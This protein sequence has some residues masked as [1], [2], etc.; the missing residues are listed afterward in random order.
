MDSYSRNHPEEK[1][2]HCCNKQR[3][4]YKHPSV[5]LWH[6]LIP[7][8]TSV[9]MQTK[10][11]RQCTETCRRKQHDEH[12]EMSKSRYYDAYVK[13]PIPERSGGGGGERRCE[14]PKPSHATRQ[15]TI[16]AC[17]HRKDALV[18]K[19]QR[20]VS[21]TNKAKMPRGKSPPRVRGKSPLP[22]LRDENSGCPYNCRCLEESKMGTED[23]LCQ[24]DSKYLSPTCCLYADYSPQSHKTCVLPKE[25]NDNKDT[26]R[27]IY[28]NSNF[29]RSSSKDDSECRDKLS[30]RF[31]PPP[32]PMKQQRE[33]ERQQKHHME[34]GCQA[35]VPEMAKSTNALLASARKQCEE[36]NLR[37]CSKYARKES[38]SS[39]SES[40]TIPSGKT[41]ISG[42]SG[43]ELRAMVRSQIE[44]QE[45]IRKSI[46]N[47]EEL[48]DKVGKDPKPTLKLPSLHLSE[49]SSS[50]KMDKSSATSRSEL[51]LTKAITKA[52]EVL[53]TADVNTDKSNKPRFSVSAEDMISS[54]VISP[55]IR[56]IQ[57]MYLNNLKEEMSLIEE[58][59]RVPCQVSKVYQ[60]ADD[61]AV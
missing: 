9:S 24:L 40:S 38:Q 4:L 49:L 25:G 54:K 36:M 42:K 23:L 50:N 18:Q 29:G 53:A 51:M 27:M 55:M 44:M 3:C 47:I 13:P 35:I 22:S 32:E 8:L 48:N 6:S 28:K 56:R 5:G 21:P 30:Y 7:S 37:F 41:V 12:S 43:E 15:Q 10:N 61:P 33:P 16:Q 39:A 26:D 17:V 52:E 46:T 14:K 57:R 1:R 34:R 45:F 20:S 59:E 60:S 19:P 11:D 31:P 2:R 58:L